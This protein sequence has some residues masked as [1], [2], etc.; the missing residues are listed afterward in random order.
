MEQQ[1]G[2]NLEEML[3][4]LRRRAR[5]VAATFVIGSALGLLL[6]FV[7]PPV[8]SSTAKILVESQQIPQDLAR[9]TV[10][11][12]V[13]ERLEMIEQRLLT[14]KNLLEIASDLNLFADRSDLT[15][16]DRVEAMR[17][18]TAIEPITISVDRSTQVA[19]FTITYR[20][21]S[22][23][24]ATAVANEFV[25]RILEQNLQQ[26]SARATETNSFFKAQIDRLQNEIADVERRISE[27]KR[28][29]E[30]RLPDAQEF[31]QEELLALQERHFEREK[32]RV[33]L[34]EQKRLITQTLAQGGSL[35]ERNL[36]PEEQ[37]LDQLRRTIA[38]RR[39]ILAESHPEVRA[40]SARINALE[41]IIVPASASAEDGSAQSLA[42]RRLSRQ[43]ELA[44][45]QLALLAEQD[46]A[47]Q[48]RQEQLEAAIQAAPAVELALAGLSR[49][50]QDLQ[51]Q[52]EIA[53]MKQA[54]AETGERLEVNRQAERFEVIEQAE[55]PTEPEAPDR[56]L[57]AAGG[58]AG[59]LTLG[60]ALAFAA[61]MM[62][63]SIYSPLELERRTGLRPVVTV[64]YIAAEADLAR[65]RRR[66]ILTA[67]AV[68]FGLPLLF[69]AVDRQVMP[70]PIL[71]EK[72]VTNSGL[73]GF[74][75]SIEQ[76]FGG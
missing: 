37:E 11:A 76:R 9:S 35:Y 36:T 50:Y 60:L 45:N 21:N 74:V 33:E 1:E 71:A 68:V 65:L 38:Q 18:A 63:R 43:L 61:E 42:E 23:G 39:A 49:R 15:P 72:L 27:F 64:P 66:R 62:N 56:M 69:W 29:N 22:P 59:S 73:D 5:L 19:A 32:R 20:A 31:R 14:R 54:E 44:N 25:T 16:T 55:R 51:K 4:K 46:E 13:A 24:E 3:Q 6:A 48:A 26:R 41:S 57:I 28:E 2:L 30:D 70:L 47:D 40:L 75:R 53:V 8:Y 17:E 12:S 34:E 67:M 58:I 52:R 10:T 7:L